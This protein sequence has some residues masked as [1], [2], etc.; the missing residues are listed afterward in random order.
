MSRVVV[1]GASGF[2]GSAVVAALRAEGHEVVSLRAP[3]LAGVVEMPDPEVIRG[4]PVVTELEALFDSADAVVNAAGDPDASSTDVGAL[5]AANALLPAVLAAATA[6]SPRMRFVHVSSAVVQGRQAVLDAGPPLDGF[7][8]YAQSKAR[9]EQLAAALAPDRTVVYRPPSVHAADR[10]VTRMIA[11]IAASPLA[12]VASP[13]TQPSPQALLANV[14]SAI[15][16]LA[17]TEQDVPPVVIHPHEGLTAA[18]TMELLGGRA[19]RR[20]PRGLARTVAYLLERVGR[21]SPAMAA[22]ARRVEMLWFG[23]EQAPSWLTSHGWV[24]VA[25]LEAWTELGRRVRSDRT[26]SEDTKERPT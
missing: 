2:V 19:P 23:Q 8:V 26:D 24:P 20:L 11:R 15:A 9:G 5:L 17:T 13:G 12:T 10:R 16:F 4:L 7:S 1:V 6:R 22:N 3:R 18:S 14:A 25:G 21:S